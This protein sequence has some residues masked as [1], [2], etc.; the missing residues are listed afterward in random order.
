MVTGLLRRA[1]RAQAVER[2]P[3][4]LIPLGDTSG[5]AS[6]LLP[7][8]EDSAARR[9]TQ[10]TMALVR[11][12][13]RPLDVMEVQALEVRAETADSGGAPGRVG[14]IWVSFSTPRFSGFCIFTLA[15]QYN[16]HDDL[17][18]SDV[19]LPTAIYSSKEN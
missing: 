6:A 15:L 4:A 18:G 19:F 2:L 12:T 8:G 17:Q 1:D 13:V 10:A 9:I 11:D 3:L 16:L 14:V 7:P 5:T